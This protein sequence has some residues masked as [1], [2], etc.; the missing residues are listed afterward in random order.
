MLTIFTH[1]P[2]TAGTSFFNRAV[3]LNF[4]DQ[5]IWTN[6]SL[7][8]IACTDL[9]EYR[10]VTGHRG[11]GLH[12]L[13]SQP[14][15]YITFL[16]DP[17][18]R[19][20]SAY[21]FILQ[22]NPRYCRHT[23]YDI[24]ASVSLDEFYAMPRFQNQMTQMLAGIEFELLLRATRSAWFPGWMLERAKENLSTRY[25][26]FGLK[27]QFAA[28]VRHIEEAMSLPPSEPIERTHKKTIGRPSMEELAPDVIARLRDAHDLDLQL[29]EY[30]VALF[31]RRMAVSA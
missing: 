26:A 9:S 15:Q 4:A 28:S 8:R 17:I 30:A 31:A 7:R 10:V 23:L 27:E 19:A 5:E 13:T 12:R 14:C 11:F 22:C 2:K 25:L 6:M 3:R 20:V 1:I 29:Y 24:A 16:R 21:Y 18:E